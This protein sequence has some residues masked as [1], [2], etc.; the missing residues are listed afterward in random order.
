M[1]ENGGQ[2]RS[3]LDRFGLEVFSPTRYHAG[4]DNVVL[5]RYAPSSWFQLVL[6][7]FPRSAWECH[8]Q[9]LCVLLMSAENFEEWRGVPKRALRRG[10][11]KRV[12]RKKGII[13]T[14]RIFGLCMVGEQ[15][16]LASRDARA[17][18]WLAGTFVFAGDSLPNG[19]D[20]NGE[21]ER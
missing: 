7:S 17:T 11:S 13:C 6:C 10:A 16:R 12:E 8:L 4:C 20:K 14:V 3:K 18:G 15:G 21:V 5:H 19:A 2:I 9:T 1:W